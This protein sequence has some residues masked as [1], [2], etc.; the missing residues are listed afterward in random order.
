M[1]ILGEWWCFVFLVDISIF[2]RRVRFVHSQ[3]IWVI[4]DGGE[5]T[6][7]LELRQV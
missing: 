6:N 7:K 4:T 1:E 3:C 5:R 2:E